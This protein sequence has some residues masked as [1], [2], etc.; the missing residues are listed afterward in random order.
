MIDIASIIGDHALN[1]SANK[2]AKPKQGDTTT[3]FNKAQQRDQLTADQQYLLISALQR[4]AG[5][6]IVNPCTG[7]SKN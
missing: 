3:L 5:S 1:S 7:K 6:F 4:T 2:L